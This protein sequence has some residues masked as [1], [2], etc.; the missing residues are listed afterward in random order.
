MARLLALLFG[1]FRV[2]LRKTLPFLLSGRSVLV[3]RGFRVR[4]R[5]FLE[6]APGS[7]LSLGTQFYGFAD[8][9]DRGLLRL[10]GPMTVEGNVAVGVGT[11][12][13]V[14]PAAKLAIGRDSYLSPGVRI[15]LSRGLTMG[16][17]CAVGWDAQ[18]LDDNY[19]PFGSRGKPFRDT[20]A[21]IVLGDHVWVGSHV[22]IFKGV[23][24][25]DGCV[26]AGGSAVQQSFDVP[27]SLIAGNP[28]RV[29][30]SDVDWD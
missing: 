24:V 12:I 18:F 22:K 19:H 5:R 11:R 26:I 2:S 16:A 14:G 25:A 10:R 4:G 17:R 15:V 28:A 13:D 27:R 7:R 3:G 1:E 23:T 20:A 8:A 30:K 9:R 6:I 21:P 29:V